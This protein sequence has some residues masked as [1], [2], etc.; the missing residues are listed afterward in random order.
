[1]RERVK[2]LKKI[3]QN[4]QKALKMQHKI[5]TQTSCRFEINVTNI[6]KNITLNWNWNFSNIFEVSW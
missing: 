1:V 6:I 5:T 3:D 2:I 4:H